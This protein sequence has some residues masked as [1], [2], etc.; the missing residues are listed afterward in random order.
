MGQSSET[1]E[2][3]KKLVDSKTGT[4]SEVVDI[5]SIDTEDENYAPVV[6]LFDSHS[7]WSLPVVF[8]DGKIVSWGTSRLDRIEKSLGEMFP[9]SKET[10]PSTSRT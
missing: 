4:V 6:K 2:A 10:A 9:A 1:I 3:I 5:E 7:I 8:I